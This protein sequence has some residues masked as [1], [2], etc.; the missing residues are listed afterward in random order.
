LGT[1]TF[2]DTL[3]AFNLAIGGSDAAQGIGGGIYV[4]GGTTTLTGK[5][6]VIGNHA[7]TSNDN[8]YGTYST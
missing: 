8:I 4:A 1:T 2:T 7:S 6:K 5:T 3:V